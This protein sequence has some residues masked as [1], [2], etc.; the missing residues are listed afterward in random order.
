MKIIFSLPVNNDKPK[1][2]T[3]LVFLCSTTSFVAQTSSLENVSKG[4]ALLAPVET[5]NS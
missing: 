2:V 5:V 1:F 3:F 4:D